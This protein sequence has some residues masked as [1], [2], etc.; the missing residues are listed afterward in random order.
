V[1][2]VCRGKVTSWRRPEW[3]QRP[4]C[5][6]EPDF[7]SWHSSEVPPTLVLPERDRRHDRGVDHTKAFD[8]A[9]PRAIVDHGQGILAHLARA[10]RMKD[11]GA[12]VA[13][14]PGESLASPRQKFLR[15]EN[16]QALAPGRSAG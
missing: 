6:T 15:L 14:G 9:H 13:G 12:D 16:G 7:R 2:V 1:T 8:A 5:D 4:T 11:R 3:A 10:H